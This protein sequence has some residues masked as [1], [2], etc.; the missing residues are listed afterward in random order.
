MSI[1]DL[2]RL[3]VQ[4]A[5]RVG[6]DI[7]AEAVHMNVPPNHTNA[8]RPDPSSVPVGFHI[9]NTEDNAPN[10]SDGTNWRDAAGTIT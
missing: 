10:Y 3:L 2:R 6:L 8:N 1:D 9:Y 7:S 5:H 4:T